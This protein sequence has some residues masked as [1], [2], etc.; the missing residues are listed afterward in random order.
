MLIG[1]KRRWFIKEHY[2]K[3]CMKPGHV[4][5]ERTTPNGKRYYCEGCAQERFLYGNIQYPPKIQN[6]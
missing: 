5:Y 4:L 1:V 3:Q 2:C 6:E